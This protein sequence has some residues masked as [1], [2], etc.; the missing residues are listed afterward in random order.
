MIHVVTPF[1]PVD[2]NLGRAYN[3][4]FKNCPE[5]DWLCLTDWDVMFLTPDAIGRLHNYVTE[6]PDTGIFT[7][8]ANRIHKGATQ[9]LLSGIE[10]I[11]YDET[12]ITKHIKFAQE[13]LRLNGTKVTKLHKH[14]SGFLMMISKN[15][16]N[17]IKFNE[18]GKCLGVDNEYS[19][20]ILA[21]GKS[22]LRMDSIFVFHLYRM[23]MPGGVKYKSHLL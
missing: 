8:C 2:K 18:D 21:A 3:E 19:D 15:T 23:G 13:L 12:D 17:E 7:C 10:N 11:Y 16:W 20:R 1:D 4:A 5:G 22:I 6:Y 9:Q 14:I